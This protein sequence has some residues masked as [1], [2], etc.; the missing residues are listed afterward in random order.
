LG[1]VEPPLVIAF[2][3]EEAVSTRPVGAQAVADLTSTHGGPLA[4]LAAAVQ[5]LKAKGTQHGLLV[6]A[7]VDTP[8]L[9]HGFAT[10][11]SA[12]LGEAAAAFAAWG[13][14]F[15]PT[16]A[17]WRIETLAGLPHD[18]LAGTGPSSP[19]ALLANLAARRVDWRDR[20][21]DN[22][23]HNVN[24]LSDL[25]HL[26]RVLAKQSPVLQERRAR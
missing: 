15:Y 19:R 3:P 2:G 24:G 5:A 20:Y 22:P 18:W 4:G 9:P 8:L 21:A 26:Q 23:F 6:S 10:A 25:L 16:N 14:D 12:A 11:M 7:A 17:I 1:P 13:E